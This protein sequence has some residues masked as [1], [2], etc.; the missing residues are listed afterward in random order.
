MMDGKDYQSTL[1][2]MYNVYNALFSISACKALGMETETILN[3]LISYQ[4]ADGRMQEFFIN[5][6]TWMLN[7]V[8]NPDGGNLTLSEF[9][10]T[11]EEK[12]L[13]FCLNDFLADVEDVSW[14][15]DID[16]EMANRNEV[17]FFIA[18]G[19]RAYDAALRMKYAGIPEEKILILPDMKKAVLE[20]KRNGLPANIMAT[21]TCLSTMV[22]ILSKEAEEQNREDW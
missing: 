18:S 10:K 12:Q 16:M 9:V 11:N 3:G 21:Y 14:I 6:D 4:K 15:W 8:K 20:A 13:I 2:G 1:K 22:T 19:K 5:K 17:K 7:L